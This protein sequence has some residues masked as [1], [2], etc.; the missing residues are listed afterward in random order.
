M[1]NA[2]IF[3][4]FE[5]KTNTNGAPYF[6]LSCC[7]IH[8][9]HNTVVTTMEQFLNISQRALGA[10][11]SQT[12]E[13]TECHSPLAVR[14]NWLPPINSTSSECVPSRT[15][16]GGGGA[17][18]RLWEGVVGANSDEGTDTMVLCILIPSL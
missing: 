16:V 5:T 14:L 1:R 2:Y 17:H 6:G 10:I 12:T 13:H 7:E 4:R 18:T 15:Q 11:I 3:P 8:V 9:Q